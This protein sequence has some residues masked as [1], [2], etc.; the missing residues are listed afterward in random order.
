MDTVKSWVFD[1]LSLTLTWISQ[2]F[3]FAKKYIIFYKN[4]FRLVAKIDLNGLKTI[5]KTFDKK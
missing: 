4:S 2:G 5:L 1:K 3:C